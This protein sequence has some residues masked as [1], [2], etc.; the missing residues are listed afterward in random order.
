M[1]N[2][3]LD[4]VARAAHAGAFRVTALDHEAADHPVEDQAV[5]E[6]LAR[7]AQEIIDCVRSLVRI[8]LHLHHAA[9]LHRDRYNRILHNMFLLYSHRSSSDRIR[10]YSTIDRP[11]RFFFRSTSTT[12]TS[13]TSP[14]LTTSRGCFTNF[15]FDMREMCTRPS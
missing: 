12:F 6:A 14:T 3:A 7:Q 9:V 1:K 8:Q 10:S 11:M 2:L 15:F 5:I 4:G 13:T